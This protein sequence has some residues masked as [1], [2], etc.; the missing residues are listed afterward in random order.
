[1][2]SRYPLS[3]SSTTHFRKARIESFFTENEKEDGEILIY[4]VG[5]HHQITE[6]EINHI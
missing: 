5:Y 2:I 3:L 1:M 6:I 4:L